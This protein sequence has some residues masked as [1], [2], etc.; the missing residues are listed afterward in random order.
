MSDD[1][2]QYL[3][4]IDKVLNSISQEINKRKSDLSKVISEQSLLQYKPDSVKEFLSKPF[5][6]LPKGHNQW[7]VIVPKFVDLQVGWLMKQTESFNVFVVDN[8]SNWLFGIPQAIKEGLDFIEP[9]PITVQ[10]DFLKVDPSLQNEVFTKYRKFLHR[11]DGTGTIKIKPRSKF[12]LVASLV[13][14]G[15]LPFTP[16]QVSKE[17]IQ[18][19]SVKIELR[20]YQIEALNK[21]LEY[22]NVGI[23]WMP[24]GGKTIIGLYVMNMLKGRKLVVVPTLT[25][26]EQW[27]ERIREYTSMQPSE[28]D[29]I[30]YNSAHKVMKKDYAF[31]IFDECHHLPAN[32]FSKL[33]LI[34][35]KYR[36]GL[37]ATPYRE[38]ERNELIFS[39]TGFPIGLD[40][41]HLLDLQI[42]RKPKV[43]VII[44]ANDSGKFTVLDQLIK[45]RDR[46]TLI[47]CD[48]IS[49]G[50]RLANRY[51][52][53]FIHGASTNRLMTANRE[54]T[55]I[56]SRV[57]D[58]GVSLE[59]LE[60]V[61]E[62]SFLFGSRRQELQRLGRLFHSSFIGEHFVLMTK[63]EF[64]MYRK[65]LF[66]IYEKGIDVTIEENNSFER[67]SLGQ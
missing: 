57:G 21:F 61:I 34:K 47:F 37:S 62:F 17:D 33:A 39:L 50:K 44:T 66:S 53:K 23:Y 59:N 32:V 46:K 31:T 16:R 43:K 13:K 22:G 8:Y 49:L 6:T 5:V 58:E 19:R 9:L 10:G 56:M 36:M 7:Y 4:N 67:P 35:T 14:D 38:D 48:G 12:S 60:R 18:E 1:F 40:W 2:K 52:L 3:S 25:L 65:R 28:Y 29:I 30:T 54:K 51:Q 63:Q 26:V 15:I 64:T 27:K 11:R 55:F 45:N 42:V 41:K 20:D 24:S